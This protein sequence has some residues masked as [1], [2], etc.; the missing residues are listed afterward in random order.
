MFISPSVAF[1]TNIYQGNTDVKMTTNIVQQAAS[2]S[3][4]SKTMNKP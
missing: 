1:D 4:I 2:K 3:T